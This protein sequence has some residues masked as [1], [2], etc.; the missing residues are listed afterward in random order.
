[1]GERLRKL[2]EGFRKAE[3]KAGLPSPELARPLGYMRRIL[4][5]EAKQWLQQHKLQPVYDAIVGRRLSTKA[6]FQRRR[7]KW[8]KAGFQRRRGKWIGQAL[9]EE[10][11]EWAKG[12]GFT[13]ADFFEPSAIKATLARGYESARTVGAAKTISKMW[14]KFSRPLSEAV[15]LKAGWVDTNQFVKRLGVAE[16]LPEKAI[17][18]YAGAVPVGRQ[19]P[20]EIAEGLLETH[21]VMSDPAA[22]EGLWKTWEGITRY[23]KGALTVPWPAY[24][25]RN[26]FSNFVL[27]WI[28]GVKNPQAYKLAT[29]LQ[30]AASQTRKLMKVRNIGWDDAARAIQWPDV[31]VAGRTMPGWQFYTTAD[32]WGILNRSI[33]ELAPEEILKPGIGK[34]KGIFTRHFQGRGIIRKKGTE[35]GTG[36]EN[37]ARL[38]H[39]IDKSQKGF[40]F[41]DAARSAKEVLFD[42]GDLSQTEKKWLRSRLVYFYTFARKN[43]E[44]QARTLF[45]QPAK[46]AVF[47]H[48][49][50]GAPAATESRE[51]FP[52]W[53][54]EKLVTRPLGRTKEGKEIRVAGMGL[55]IEEA[56]GPLAGPG[57]GVVSRLR[58]IMTR[59]LARTAP[60]IKTP[61][62][63]TTGYNLYFD[64]P[65]EEMTGAPA[66]MRAL[67]KWGRKAM[68]VSEI[69]KEGQPTRYTMP[70]YRR[71]AM[72]QTPLSRL[73]TSAHTA[74]STKEPGC[75]WR[76]WCRVSGREFSTRKKRGNTVCVRLF[77]S[78]CARHRHEVRCGNLA[79]TMCLKAKQR[80][81]N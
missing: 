44:L 72:E 43:L 67:P 4:T 6:G 42:Y 33:G 8:T 15:P 69:E 56:F 7:G 21:R 5:P 59:Q 66:Y 64:K 76:V 9:R 25:I 77:D 50:G 73:S 17:T 2:T 11:N 18:K 52:D 23:M 34:A 78:N 46:Q 79:V 65:I 51:L 49:A 12:K 60:L 39:F 45:Q 58:R 28:G 32:D 63:F 38:A 37:N 40:N 22:L 16:L 70:A 26:M 74:F 41:Q 80:T 10:I 1:M 61:I 48:L 19:I 62:E 36:I 81:R 20:R 13:G 71:W 47:S 68:G 75:E 54:Q 55:P 31:A 30:L 27:N 57:T 35:I 14:N 29:Q 53:W 24:H 3:I